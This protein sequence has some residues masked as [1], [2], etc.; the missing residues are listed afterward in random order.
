MRLQ[1]INDSLFTI[2]KIHFIREVV[3]PRSSSELIRT[4]EMMELLA[5]LCVLLMAACYCDYRKKKIPNYL[6]V[7]MV[8]TGVVWRF[9]VAGLS[10]AAVCVLQMAV[11]GGILFPLFKIGAVGAG[12]V[13]LFGVTAGCLPF[14]KIFVFLFVSLLIAAIISLVKFWYYGNLCER[15]KYFMEYL[16]DVWKSGSWR[17][18]LENEADSPDL[19]LCLSGPVLLGLLLYMGG[20]Y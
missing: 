5:A 10:G 14:E 20:V 2:R 4:K 3:S 7:A 12:D 15:L 13:K 19:R 11:I 8:L 9:L 18:Y 17:L 1:Q 16:T 6:I